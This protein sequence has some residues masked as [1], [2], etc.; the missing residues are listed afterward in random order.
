MS[1]YEFTDLEL[2][3]CTVSG[4]VEFTATLP[5]DIQVDWSSLVFVA[6]DSDLINREFWQSN[7][8]TTTIMFASCVAVGA[9]GLEQFRNILFEKISEYADRKGLYEE[10]VPREERD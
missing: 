3:G 1:T 10:Y 7:E 6:F 2:R 5:N 9:F 4:C 8:T